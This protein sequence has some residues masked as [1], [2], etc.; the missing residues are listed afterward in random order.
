[1]EKE[2]VVV[3]VSRQLGSGGSYIADG[4]A[5]ELGSLSWIG[6]SS[7]RPPKSGAGRRGRGGVRGEVLQPRGEARQRALPRDPG[8]PL[9]AAFG[10]A[11]TTGTSLCWKAGS[12]R[13]LSMITT[14]SS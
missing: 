1:M 5:K 14:R 10:E 12:S 9:S 3:T 11:S 8:T 6:K 4:V 13:A 2:R 7:A